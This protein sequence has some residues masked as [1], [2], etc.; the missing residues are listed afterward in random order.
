M[1]GGEGNQDQA[2]EHR[3]ANAE[4]GAMWVERKVKCDWLPGHRS[5]GYPCAFMWVRRKQHRP[6]AY[7]SRSSHIVC[8]PK[9]VAS[10]P[11]QSATA[12]PTAGKRL[13]AE[14]P[15]PSAQQS[16]D[17]EGPPGVLDRSAG[18]GGGGAGGGGGMQEEEAP[19]RGP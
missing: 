15:P 18:G 1:G 14:V 12:T 7:R 8:L 3:A 5:G 6:D 17:G 16:R 2:V 9:A 13:A 10:G 4:Q 11:S 19:K